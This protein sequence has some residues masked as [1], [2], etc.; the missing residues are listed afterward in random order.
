MEKVAGLHVTAENPKVSHC[1][2]PSSSLLVRG[3]QSSP[4]R[5]HQHPSPSPSR[6]C[7]CCWEMEPLRLEGEG[8]N[9]LEQT[10]SLNR[11]LWSS[12]FL[13]SR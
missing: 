2:F 6:P 8:C 3:H 7:S 12:S 11:D 10:L 13:C 5:G 4:P 1:P 9:L